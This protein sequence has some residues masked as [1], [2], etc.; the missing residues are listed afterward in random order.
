MFIAI[1]IGIE[2]DIGNVKLIGKQKQVTGN[3]SRYK[4]Y[5]INYLNAYYRKQ[6]NQTILYHY[7]NVE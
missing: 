6:K 4:A 3:I 1:G 7:K 2:I 5:K